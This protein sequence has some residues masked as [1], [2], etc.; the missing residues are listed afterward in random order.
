MNASKH[1]QTAVQPYPS[2]SDMWDNEP[3]RDNQPEKRNVKISQVSLFSGFVLSFR[4]KHLNQ[5]NRSET[6]KFKV[7]PVQGAFWCLK[8]LQPAAASF[9]T[10]RSVWSSASLRFLSHLRKRSL[11]LRLKGSLHSKTLESLLRLNFET[12]ILLGC[13]KPVT[14]FGI[15]LNLDCMFLCVVTLL[16]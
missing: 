11:D 1:H 5:T 2:N 7:L 3:V 16:F 12:E 6:I 4:S 14:L 13:L 15:S 10:V 9:Y 8:A